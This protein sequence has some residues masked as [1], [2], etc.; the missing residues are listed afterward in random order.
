MKDKRPWIDPNYPD[1]PLYRQGELLGLSRSGYYYQP[2]PV[3]EEDLLLMNLIDEQYP[4]TPYYG[5][6]RMTY[7]LNQKKYQVNHKRVSRLMKEMGIEAIYPKPRLSTNQTEQ[8]IYPYLLRNII[9]SHS[10]QVWAADITYIR[11]HQGFWYLV[12]IMDWYSR[13]VVS[14]QLSNTWETSFCLVALEGALERSGPEIF[15]TDQGVQ[16]TSEEFTSTLK[17][18]GCRISM[19][20]KGRVFDNIFGERLWRSVKYEEGYLHEYRTGWDAEKGLSRYF[21]HYNEER[22]HQSLQNMTPAEVYLGGKQ[23]C[24]NDF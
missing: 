2:V 14:F 5:V 19:D 12:A 24:T 15:N 11:M 23:M 4:R 6:R 9:P 13:Y 10:N 16:F 3:R 22:S 21:C 20:G 18:A 8:V 1:I 17:Q 7:A